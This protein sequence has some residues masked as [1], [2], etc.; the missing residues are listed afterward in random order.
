MED[1][2]GSDYQYITF[3]INENPETCRRQQSTLRRWNI[4][5]LNVD[6]FG[7]VLG[8]NEDSIARITVGN[9]QEAEE[10]V[11]ATMEAITHACETMPRKK[12][13][14]RK[15]PTYWWTQEIADLRRECLRLRRAA[16]R[17]RHG[18]EAETIAMEHREAKRE[19]RRAIN[20][21]KE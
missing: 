9:K 5:K 11:A 7:E 8:R 1:Y 14:H 13:H 4:L 15:R 18:N 2:T 6:R 20:R 21:S 12:S 16:Q 17:H 19:L 10:L 3:A